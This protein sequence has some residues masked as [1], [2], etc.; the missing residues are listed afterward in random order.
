MHKRSFKRW[1]LW[2]SSLLC[3]ALLA[4]L[5]L[6]IRAEETNSDAEAATAEASQKP[7]VTKTISIENADDFL[8]FAQ[9]CRLDTYSIGLVVELEEDIDLTGKEFEAIPTFSGVLK[10]ND[11]VI[12]GL[13]LETEGSAQGLFRYIQ[14]G[15]VVQDLHLEGSIAPEGSRSYVGSL[16]GENAGTI[17]NCSFNGS[18][19]GGEHVGGLVGSNALTGVIESCRVYG[20]I[21]GHHFVGGFVG[22]NKGVI[23]SC[24]NA[25]N[26]NTTVHE[27][28]VGLGDISLDSVLESESAVTVTDVGGIAGSNMGVIRGCENLGNVGYEKIGYNMGGIAGSQSGYVVDCVNRGQ[29]Q[30]RKEVGGIVGQ[31]EPTLRMEFDEDTLQ[32]LGVE[33][34]TMMGLAG[35]TM[36]SAQS[37]IKSQMAELEKQ[38]KDAEKA[39]TQMLDEA[40][41]PENLE[42]LE[43]PEIDLDEI[44][45][46]DLDVSLPDEDALNAAKNNLSSSIG[47]LSGTMNDMIHSGQSTLGAF[48]SNMQAL[49]NQMGVIGSTIQNADEDLGGSLVDVSDEDT[50]EETGGKVENCQNY[51]AVCGDRNVGGIVGAMA[52]ESSLDPELDVTVAG[53]LSLNFEGEIRAVVLQCQNEADVTAYKQNGGGIAGYMSLGLVRACENRG[54]VQG[55]SASYLG[56]I[57]GRGD[58]G[59]LRSNHVRC[60]IE[61][62]EYVGGIAGTAV[63]VS[64]CLSL[65]QFATAAE[66]M[67]GVLGSLEEVTED[68]QA[69]YYAVGEGDLGGIDGISYEGK[70]QAMDYKDFFRLEQLPEDFQTVRVHF[71]LEDGSETVVK[72]DYGEALK[73]EKIPAVPEK[74]GADGRWDG[75]EELDLSAMYYD[76]TLTAT[77]EAYE[78]I[79]ATDALRSDGRPILLAGSEFG[80]DARLTIAE[81]SEGPVSVRDNEIIVEAWGVSLTNAGETAKLRYLPPEEQSA[82]D[83]LEEEARILV[84]DTAGTWREA[85]YTVDGSYV[86]FEISAQDNGFCLVVSEGS[87]WWLYAAIGG[88][89]FVLVEAAIILVIVKRRKKENS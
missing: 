40:E 69:N 6:A 58:G 73:K 54:A 71:V 26:L 72:L 64:D 43:L 30:G 49:S 78:K 62:A 41:V 87:S 55:A 68:I 81:L 56:G 24:V 85:T 36:N 57:A 37:G 84:R 15:A 19:S 7:I 82:E 61:G 77:Y 34:D 70:A 8:R 38:A 28:A 86:I 13:N 3:L 59:Y 44:E 23:R 65:P 39:L 9:D 63:V 25:A 27:N 80:K 17:R 31:M 76:I 35:Q 1:R 67:G 45:M 12:R 11:H 5:P 83:L 52:Y 48:S 79:L 53:D 50:A 10:G 51:G 14:A 46:P 66:K 20:S 2:L 4:N 22:D 21:Q 33:M 32:K 42:D 88:G 29:I 75:I 18:V 16:A 74:D 89:A 60:R 47:K